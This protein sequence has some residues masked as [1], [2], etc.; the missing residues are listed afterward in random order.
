M[1]E[2]KRQYKT[3]RFD[4]YSKQTIAFIIVFLL[5]IILNSCPG[6]RVTYEYTG[7]LL[8][9]D[10]GISHGGFE[11]GSQ[12]SAS[13]VIRGTRGDLIL[14]HKIGLGDYLRKHEFSVS[15]FAEMAGNISFKIEG[16]AASLVLIEED[17][18]WNRQ[19]DGYF[20]GNKT[21]DL[22]ERIGYLPIEPFLGFNSSFYIDLR[23]LPQQPEPDLIGLIAGLQR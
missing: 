2:N 10:S 8:A 7:E 11:W 21:S 18:I 22:S 5:F 17:I 4:F 1:R 19:Y 20:S 12:Y 13:L 23:L 9:N 14:T 16:R 15:E 6:S 3:A